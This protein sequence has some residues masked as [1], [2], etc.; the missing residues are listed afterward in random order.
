VRSNLWILFAAVALVLLI[1]CANV[2]NLLLARAAQ[3][4]G[5]TAMR[6]ALGAS[7]SRLVRQFLTESLLLAVA[8]C[9][10]GLGALT[11][12]IDAFA[13]FLPS[14]LPRAEHIAIDGRVLGFTVVVSLLTGLAF[15][16][17]PAWQGA[18]IDLQAAIKTG[19]RS[20]QDGRAGARVRSALI[21][22]QVAVSLV[23]LV[24]AGLLLKSFAAL[25][26]VDPG[27][28]PH[29]VLTLR[30]SLSGEKYR[31]GAL[32]SAFFDRLA[33]QVQALPGVESA[34]L[35]FPLPFS[36]PI[37]NQP[38]AIPG[39]PANLGDELSTQFNIVSPDYFR[40]LGIRVT[41]GRVFTERDQEGAPPVAVINETLARRIWPDEN[42]IGKRLTVGRG[43]SATIEREVVGVFAD[44]K[45][46][47]LDSDPLLQICVPYAQVQMRTLYLAV[48][49][50]IDASSLLAPVREQIKALDPDLP[51]TDLALW[52]ERLA[53]S[54]APRRVTTWLLAS[55]AAIALLLAVVGLYGVMSYLVAQRTREFGIRMA[56]GAKMA[57]ILRLVVGHGMKLV[58]L[59]LAGG[60]LVSLGLTR[61][62]GGLLFG[63]QPTDPITFAVVSLLLAAVGT[64]ACWLP[65]RRAAKVDP[66]VALRCE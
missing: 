35:V 40:A 51:L 62:L 55:F 29:N 34:A 43:R 39:R 2:G 49:G 38:F 22:A 58:L 5:E 32:Q 63:V 50:R 65:A 12:G 46:R 57:D 13:A 3:R 18:R 60:V 66:M 1:A 20:G 16:L 33:Q 59:G 52:N 30:V 41:R 23:L 26:G 27:F 31:G 53:G 24:G 47:E 54:I 36:G 37:Q 44:I 17:L 9:V 61:M 11:V 45:Q 14:S 8:G 10:L 28:N 7:R 15:G 48:R 64:L 25:S 42:P 21:V 4:G 6:A 56:L 19:G